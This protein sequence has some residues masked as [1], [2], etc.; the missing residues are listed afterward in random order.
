MKEQARRMRIRKADK[1]LLIRLRIY[2]K[3]AEAVAEFLRASVGDCYSRMR[4]Y[5][6]DGSIRR[7]QFL[8]HDGRR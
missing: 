8:F 1:G 2:G 3:L 7:A 4:S 5:R 6:C